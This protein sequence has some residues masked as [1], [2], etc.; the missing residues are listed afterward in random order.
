VLQQLPNALSLA[1]ILAAPV[2]IG[3]ALMQYERAFAAILIAALVTDILDG[4]IARRLQLQTQFGAMLDSIGDITTL[5]AAAVGIAAFHPAVW[6]HH[7]V[8]ICAV[9]GG[10]A[11]ECACALLRYGRLSSFHTYAS[12]AAGYALGIFIAVLFAIGFVSPLFYAAATWSLLS[13]VE[14]L[15][16]LW[17]LPQWRADVRGLWWLYRE[18]S[19]FQRG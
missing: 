6:Q 13:I 5:I 17:R 4:W 19:D 18:R 1:R 3:L 12:K 10:W 9:L 7:F 14:E 8:A 16:L 15:L 2:L 11:F